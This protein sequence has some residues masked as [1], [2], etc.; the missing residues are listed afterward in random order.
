MEGREVWEKN[1]VVRFVL[2]VAG[3]C[4]GGRKKKKAVVTKSKRV[5]G[6]GMVG[7]GK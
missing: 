4:S 1:G 7:V 5:C 3:L 2:A 6:G